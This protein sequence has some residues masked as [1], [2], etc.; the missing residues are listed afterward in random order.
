M[1]E[2]SRFE[3]IEDLY[4]QAAATAPPLRAAFLDQACA[5]DPEL[6][7]EVESLL[8]HDASSG[9]DFFDRPIMEFA[10]PALAAAT[11]APGSAIGP[12]RILREV[13]RGGMGVVY[14][15]EQQHPVRRRVALKLIQPGMDSSQW[16][17]RFEIERQALAM[18]DHPNITTVLDAGSTPTGRPFL[19]M[20]WIDGA[21]ITTYCASRDLP[22]RDRLALFLPVCHAIQHAHHKGILHRDIKPSNILVPEYDAKPVPKVIDFGVAKPLNDRLTDHTL[23]TQAGALV[24]TL[25]YMSPEQVSGAPGGLDTRSDVYSLGVVLCEILAG[26]PPFRRSGSGPASEIDTISRILR[27][28]PKPP[29]ARVAD[30]QLARQIR[31]ELDQIVLKALEKDVNRR[32]DS[33]GALAEDL[34]CWL[35]GEPVSAVPPSRVY[36]FRRFVHRYRVPL[37]TATAFALL[38]I[39]ASVFSIREALRARDAEQTAAAVN[40][41]LQNGVLAQASAYVQA[42]PGT[43]PDPDLTVR[44]ALDRAAARIDGSFAGRPLVEASI[45]QTIGATYLDLGLFQPAI[46]HLER[47]VLLRRQFSGDRNP[48]TLTARSRL[49]RAVLASGDRAR[50]RALATEVLAAQRAIHGDRTP[51]TIAALYDMATLELAL[52]NFAE[53]ERL[54]THMAELRSQTLGPRHPDTL[55]SLHSLGI[56]LFRR[57]AYTR[58]IALLTDVVELRRQVRGNDHPETMESRSALASAYVLGGQGAKAVP[59][60][61]GVLDWQQRVLGPIHP[62]TLATRN[63]LGDA[64]SSSGSLTEGAAV[65]RECVALATAANLK[66]F[67]VQSCQNNLANVLNPLGD[68]AGAEAIFRKLLAADIAAG[69]ESSPDAMRTAS[70]LAATLALAGKF[71]E[72]EKLFDHVI[73]L[74]TQKLGPKDPKT[75]SSMSSR[76]YLYQAMGRLA[77]AERAHRHVSTLRAAALGPDHTNTRYSRLNLAEVLV[78][79]A[80]YDEARTILTPLAASLPAEPWMKFS[81]MSLLGDVERAAG[82]PQRAQSLLRQAIDG[83]SANPVPLQT[84]P[85]RRGEIE[86]AQARLR[87]LNSH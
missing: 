65:L 77:D 46:R 55:L 39:A 59:L 58:A 70:N 82:N 74:R 23:H 72:A 66:I 32:Y 69:G 40:D 19:V 27:D 63:A 80:K 57:E 56:A 31:G 52:A 26:E 15:A 34:R 6:R 13:G 78:A 5:G 37:A 71:A 47:A 51:A 50:A 18:M 30:P 76:G 61:R 48:D 44:T 8:A 86:R 7:R 45:R 53:A 9:A 41:F 29:S 49:A 24:G 1:T 3:R 64:L 83:L 12:Y 4:H 25:E 75:L 33:V 35:S 81:A 62:A 11:F 10:A 84:R 14:Q 20:E 79:Q 28:D 67:I 54:F 73:A 68:H 22:L 21:P 17:A 36:R 42:A 16:I 2:P 38:L 87:L 60:L 85:E 43:R